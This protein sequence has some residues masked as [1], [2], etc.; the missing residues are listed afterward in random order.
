MGVCESD[1]LSHPFYLSFSFLSGM[2]VLHV[3]EKRG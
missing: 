1:P 2:G 3:I